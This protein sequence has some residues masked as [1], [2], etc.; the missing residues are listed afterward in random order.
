MRRAPP[1]PGDS[2]RARANVAKLGGD[3]VIGHTF[4]TVW[5]ARTTTS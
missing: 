3:F 5:V 1:A 2:E 4:D